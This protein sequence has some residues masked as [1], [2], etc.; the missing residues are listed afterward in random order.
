M[1]DRM[2]YK[3][4]VFK[5]IVCCLPSFFLPKRLFFVTINS[6]SNWQKSLDEMRQL[7][8]D[9]ISLL[10]LHNA[11]ITLLANWRYYHAPAPTLIASCCV[12]EG[13]HNC[14]HHSRHIWKDIVRITCR[15]DGV[16]QLESA[17]SMDQTRIQVPVIN[18]VVV[19]WW[20]IFAAWWTRLLDLLL[21]FDYI[22]HCRELSLTAVNR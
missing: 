11:N 5:A 4:K 15:R 22:C 17:K 3:L 14:F 6:F 7:R 9:G 21:L 13:F 19:Q 12:K 8:K 20:C 2:R 16:R 1:T 18:G 10:Y